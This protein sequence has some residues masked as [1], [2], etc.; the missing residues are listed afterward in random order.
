MKEGDR[1]IFFSDGVAQAGVGLGSLPMAERKPAAYELTRI[2][3]LP[4]VQGNGSVN[5]F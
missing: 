4:D 1:L 5:A 2:Y 3:L